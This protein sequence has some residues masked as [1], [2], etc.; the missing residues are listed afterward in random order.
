VHWGKKREQQQEED[1]FKE[2]KDGIE[3]SPIP[4]DS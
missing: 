1:S 4:E 3:N 2:Y